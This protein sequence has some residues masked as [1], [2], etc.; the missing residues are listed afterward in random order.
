MNKKHLLGLIASV[1]TCGSLPFSCGE[2]EISV[3]TYN[4]HGLPESITGSNPEENM[5]QISPSLNSYDIVAIQEDFFYHPALASSAEHPYLTPSEFYLQKGEELINPSGLTLFSIFP[6]EKY[7]LQ[8]WWSCN[9]TVD[10]SSDCL[11]PKGLAAA[12]IEAMPGVMVDVYNCHMDAG[13]S[14]GDKLTRDKQIPQLAYLLNTRSPYRAVIVACDTNIEKEDELQL[15]QLL[16]LTG[17]KDSCQELDCPE[18]D[19]IDRVLYRS[20]ISVQLEPL[21]WYIPKEFVNKKGEDLSD[22]KP[23]A[24]DFKISVGPA[25]LPLQ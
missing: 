17:L 25:Y 11:A 18:P 15:E 13:N 7:F 1:A 3:L 20:G 9:G 16:S 14:E 19:R 21:R 22:H 6:T 4:V 5:P 10:Q 24:V 2:A 8:R 23:V 12:E